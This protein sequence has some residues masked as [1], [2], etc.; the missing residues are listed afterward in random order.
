MKNTYAYQ[1]FPDSLHE[2]KPMSLARQANDVSYHLSVWV[3]TL[4]W[5]LVD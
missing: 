2:V 3:I 1:E 4:I 5:A